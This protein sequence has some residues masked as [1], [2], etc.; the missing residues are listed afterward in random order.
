MVSTS[1]IC[2]YSCQI[3]YTEDFSYLNLNP[4]LIH[5]FLEIFTLFSM[6]FC[7]LIRSDSDFTLFFLASFPSLCLLLLRQLLQSLL[8][9]ST[10]VKLLL[11]GEQ[12]MED[13]SFK[14]NSVISNFP[15]T[16]W[17][18]RWPTLSDKIQKSVKNHLQSS[19]Q[20]N[21]RR[22][23]TSEY[24]CLKLALVDSRTK[25]RLI[26]KYLHEPLGAG[27]IQNKKV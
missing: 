14:F 3:R 12:R 21:P 13:P 22:L 2:T 26:L 9:T 7:S 5:L 1:K 17:M 25:Y 24:W 15:G 20:K 18:Q 19:H 23:C 16:T 27:K 4:Q 10:C 6:T 8:F 11:Y